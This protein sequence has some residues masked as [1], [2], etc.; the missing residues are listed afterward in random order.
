MDHRIAA[1]IVAFATAVTIPALAQQRGVRV[2]SPLEGYR[3]MELN[4]PAAD[5]DDLDRMPPVLAE[6][7]A[8]AAQL[9]VTS[10]TMIAADPLRVSNG[11]TQV[12][13]LDGRQGWVESAK[14]KPWARPQ[15]PGASCTPARLSN[16]RIGFDFGPHR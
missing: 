13:H 9:G 6:P 11:F 8:N 2:V 4:V 5:L 16:G 15:S 3:C 10:A 1:A 7:Q 14:L 12:L